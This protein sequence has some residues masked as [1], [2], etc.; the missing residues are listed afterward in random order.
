MEKSELRTV[1]R[2]G[3]AQSRGADAA[4]TSTASWRTISLVSAPLLLGLINLVDA[5]VDKQKGLFEGDQLYRTSVVSGKAEARAI[6][7]RGS[8]SADVIYKERTAGARQE[9]ESVLMGAIGKATQVRLQ[10]KEE[11]EVVRLQAER[12]RA[13]VR[14]FLSDRFKR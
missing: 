13:A 8:K 14:Q 9:A 4:K 1:A 6:S 11:S 7:T 3:S 12:T 2:P 5:Y 10:A